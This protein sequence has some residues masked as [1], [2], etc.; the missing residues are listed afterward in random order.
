MAIA[1]RSKAT[2]TQSG[3]T[4]THNLPSGYQA[5]DVLIAAYREQYTTAAKPDLVSLFSGLGWTTVSSNSTREVVACK[6]AA[7]SETTPT[8]T[9]G[10]GA[11]PGL[12]VIAA[13]SGCGS[14]ATNSITAYFDSTQNTATDHYPPAYSYSGGL[15]GMRVRID[16]YELGWPTWDSLTI[17][18]YTSIDTQSS[19]QGS[20]GNYCRTKM[21]RQV[22]TATGPLTMASSQSY[23]GAEGVSVVGTVAEVYLM[24]PPSLAG[25]FFGSNF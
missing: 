18:S 11:Y 22:I 16:L 20:Y 25:L 19:D 14:F 3:T 2:G 12:G 24:P 17:P 21:Q 8:M 15:D 10:S 13:F 4:W 9:V 5:G 1:Y 6:I 23:I 7:A